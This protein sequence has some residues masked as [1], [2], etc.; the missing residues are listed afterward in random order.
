MDAVDGSGSLKH[1][2]LE[3][4]IHRKAAVSA[5][6]SPGSSKYTEFHRSQVDAP[7]S[8]LKFEA[9]R[10]SD[11]EELNDK[12]QHQNEAIDEVEKGVRTANLVLCFH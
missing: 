1:D 12:D 10:I 11:V 5:A 4:K 7:N 8:S 2:V 9:P 6:N 3:L